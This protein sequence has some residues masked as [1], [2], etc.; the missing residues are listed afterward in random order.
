V[1]CSF[2]IVSQ[3]EGRTFTLNPDFQPAPTLLDA[4]LSAL[5][6]G[7]Q[8][9][10]IQ[11]Y[12]ECGVRLSDATSGFEP[13]WFDEGTYHRWKPVLKGAWR[14]GFDQTGEAAHVERMLRLL[15]NEPRRKKRVYVLIGNEP[16]AA[17]I[18][19]IRQ[20]IAWGAEPYAQ[21]LLALDTLTREPL[22]RF[23][24][25]RQRLHDLARWCNR[26]FWTH[27]PL[28]DY[29]PRQRDP[30]PFAGWSV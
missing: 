17:C 13:R 14:C 8:G 3:R 22:V 24:W 4:N 20:V 27:V 11:R 16:M 10:V 21:P 12:Q 25:T 26:L 29:R 18:E 5:P 9:F 28:G 30:P 2:C 7:W 19:R 6:V 23:D 15:G 1:G